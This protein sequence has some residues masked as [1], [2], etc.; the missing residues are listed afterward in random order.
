[1]REAHLHREAVHADVS[2]L[3]G[4][5]LRAR[6][7]HDFSLSVPGEVL[8]LVGRKLKEDH[9]SRPSTGMYELCRC[10]DMWLAQCLRYRPADWELKYVTAKRRGMSELTVEQNLMFCQANRLSTAAVDGAYHAFPWFA[11]RRRQRPDR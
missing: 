8:G 7:V 4:Q 2:C 10:E 5:R 3:A 9:R 6:V 11:E 1:M